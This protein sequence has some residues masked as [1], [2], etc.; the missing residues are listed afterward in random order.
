MQKHTPFRNNIHHSDIQSNIRHSQGFRV[1]IQW[2]SQSSDQAFL[3]IIH[4]FNLKT[5]GRSRGGEQRAG[6]QD[7]EEQGLRIHLQSL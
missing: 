5:E 6:E 7:G 2:Q 4:V 3:F 1:Q